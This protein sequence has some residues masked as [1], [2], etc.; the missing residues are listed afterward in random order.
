MYSF[1]FV[2]L[3]CFCKS[4]YHDFVCFVICW[5]CVLFLLQWFSSSRL[6]FLGF[7]ALRCEPRPQH[8]ICMRVR[9]RARVSARAGARICA[10]EGEPLA[11]AF[12]SCCADVTCQRAL[13]WDSI[14][15]TMILVLGTGFGTQNLGI[16]WL[17]SVTSFVVSRLPKS[18]LV[19]RR[20]QRP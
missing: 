3:L 4:T 12:G 1:F 5:V 7:L 17:H 18:C 19:S 9:R 11:Q 2:F 8:G 14:A 10:F 20:G 15:H 13:G 16:P 6:L